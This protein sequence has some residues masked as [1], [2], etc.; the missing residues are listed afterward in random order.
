MGHLAEKI[1][2]ALAGSAGVSPASRQTSRPPFWRGK[3]AGKMPALPQI[4][5]GIRVV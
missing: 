1:P 2:G 5:I 3:H 4:K